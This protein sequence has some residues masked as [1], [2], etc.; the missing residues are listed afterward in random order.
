MQT[1]IFIARMIG[2]VLAAIGLVFLLDPAAAGAL[3][4]SSWRAR[5]RCSYRAC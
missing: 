2:P 4:R 5:R 3:P 1:S